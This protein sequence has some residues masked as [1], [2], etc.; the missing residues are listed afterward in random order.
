MKSAWLV[1]FVVL[2]GCQSLAESAQL[3]RDVQQL[4]SLRDPTPQLPT[5]QFESASL[6]QAPGKAQLAAWYCPQVTGLAAPCQLAFGAPPQP[7]QPEVANA[8]LADLPAGADDLDREVA[9]TFPYPVARPY[10]DL[11]R[12]R[13]LLPIQTREKQAHRAG[14]RFSGAVSGGLRGADLALPS[15]ERR[16]WP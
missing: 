7:E 3:L 4:Q 13:A 6:V 10:L 8:L 2:A 5:I 14:L 9:L 1:A 12:E 11:L 16:V 15:V